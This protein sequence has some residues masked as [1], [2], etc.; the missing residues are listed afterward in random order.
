MRDA[1][2]WLT[3]LDNAST[4]EDKRLAF[5]SGNAKQFAEGEQ[6]HPHLEEDLRN[7]GLFVDYHASIEQFLAHV[8]AAIGWLTDEWIQ[9]HVDSDQINEQAVEELRSEYRNEMRS[10]LRG[11]FSSQLVDFSV[12]G[13]SLSHDKEYFVYER[14]DDTLYVEAAYYGSCYAE[15]TYEVQT[16]K[17]VWSG[18]YED[19]DLVSELERRERDVSLSASVCFSVKERNVSDLRVLSLSIHD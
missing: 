19:Y 5:V 1:L 9:E 17:Q 16:F 8:G 18:E 13:V 3:V 6:L 11:P 7:G 4:S 14:S 15:A 12:L 10:A 2:L